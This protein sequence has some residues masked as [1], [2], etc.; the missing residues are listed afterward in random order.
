MKL[1]IN[2]MPSKSHGRTSEV[3]EQVQKV[4]K[5]NKYNPDDDRVIREFRKKIRAI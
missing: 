3:K 5:Q 1:R 4:I 2:V